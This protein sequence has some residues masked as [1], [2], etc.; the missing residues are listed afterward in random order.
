MKFTFCHCDWGPGVHSSVKDW[1]GRTRRSRALHIV[2]DGRRGVTREWDGK[3]R[4]PSDGGPVASK[5]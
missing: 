3:G 5:R 4:A 1:A 2:N